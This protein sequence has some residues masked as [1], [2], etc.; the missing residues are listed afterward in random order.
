[1]G[2]GRKGVLM[3]VALGCGWL[4]GSLLRT[5]PAVPAAELRRS[6]WASERLDEAVPPAIPARVETAA[7]QAPDGML[8][9]SRLQ[10]ARLVR[11]PSALHIPLS[12]YLPLT[13]PE[14]AIP[15][16]NDIPLIGRLF[17]TPLASGL[18]EAAILFGWDD[19]QTRK[20]ALILA[21]FGRGVAAAE[22][23]GAS[24][25][26]L[27]AGG[28]RLD[29]SESQA[30]REATAARFRQALIEQLGARDADR[31]ASVTRLEGFAEPLPVSHTITVSTKNGHA[32]ISSDNGEWI[33]L[34]DLESHL[35]SSLVSQLA[36]AGP[37]TRVRHLGLEIDWARVLADAEAARRA[38]E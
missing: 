16:L 21:N 28:L 22:K 29:F 23:A 24:L 27:P 19:T 32:S 5:R 4:A 13:H 11:D 17:E 26:Y 31:F 34:L 38:G 14:E 20:V 25:E 6:S 18:K 8:G 7:L 9:F 1:M 33:M 3:V 30:L 10:W 2:F 15:M 12:E 37:T 35:Q 36:E